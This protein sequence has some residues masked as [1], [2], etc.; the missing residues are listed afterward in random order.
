[1]DRD[2]LKVVGDSLERILQDAPLR[3]IDEAN[4]LGAQADALWQTLEQNGFAQLGV[5][6]VH[7]GVGASLADCVAIASVCGRYALPAPLADTIIAKTL[8]SV[9]DIPPP[10]GR[11]GL[12]QTSERGLYLAH[13]SQVE[14]AILFQDGM[15]HLVHLKAGIEPLYKAEDGA[16]CLDKALTAS[17]HAASAPDWLTESSYSAIGALVRAGLMAGA[18][19]SAL[20]MT[21]EHT[22]QREQFGRPIAKFQAVQHLLSDIACETAAAIASVGLAQAALGERDALSQQALNDIA[23]AKIRCGIAAGAVS[24]AAHQAHGAMGFTWE[25]DL[26]RFTRRLWQWQDEF[27]SHKI[28]ASQLGQSLGLSPNMSLWEQISA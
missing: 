3:A 12:A 2:D 20:E 18:M 4:G 19:Q 27:G 7:G 21:L 17:V 26:G 23:I 25:Y 9:C 24:A 28:W 22:G 13:A 11:I 15:L 10:E 5:R 16:A 8:L 14:T 6:E 1:M